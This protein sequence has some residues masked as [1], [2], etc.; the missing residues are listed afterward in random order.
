MLSL[1]SG[2]ANG[3]ARISPRQSG[4]WGEINFDYIARDLGKRGAF[5]VEDFLEAAAIRIRYF[6]NNRP[7]TSSEANDDAGTSLEFFREPFW[8][9]FGLAPPPEAAQF[10]IGRQAEN[11]A[12]TG[13]AARRSRVPVSRGIRLYEIR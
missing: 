2:K 9:R 6:P 8:R 7:K 11:V 4:R 5:L 1:D 13:D 12:A 10:H 3:P